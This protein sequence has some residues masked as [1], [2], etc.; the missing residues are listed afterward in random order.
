MQ[1]LLTNQ[2]QEQGSRI[3]C[4]PINGINGS[5]IETL[6]SAIDFAQLLQLKLVMSQLRLNLTCE[7]SVGLSAQVV[8]IL[9]VTCS[10]GS[11]YSLNMNNFL[12]LACAGQP[13]L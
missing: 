11:Q 8:H 6:P 3:V 12:V 9:S 4:P 13:S 2:P 10:L 7:Q 5:G 1:A